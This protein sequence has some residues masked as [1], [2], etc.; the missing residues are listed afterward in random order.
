MGSEREASPRSR[1]AEVACWLWRLAPS[2]K[3][4]PEALH[5][6]R[7][8]KFLGAAESDTWSVLI[9]VGRF[10]VSENVCYLGLWNA[11]RLSLRKAKP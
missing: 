6:A 9:Y 1:F 3:E 10:N 2:R 7:L 5:H 11:A 4:A 8:H